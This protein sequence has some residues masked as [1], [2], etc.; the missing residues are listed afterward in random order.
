MTP[1]S[2]HSCARREPGVA[3]PKLVPARGVAARIGAGR[4]ARFANRITIGCTE[5][6]A[7]TNSGCNA[8]A[9][10]SVMHSLLLE[11][12][13]FHQVGGGIMFTTHFVAKTVSVL[14]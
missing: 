11:V 12:Y 4:G 6:L 3:E 13:F 14:L 8:L 9:F 2:A 5:R 1:V 7:S 10:H